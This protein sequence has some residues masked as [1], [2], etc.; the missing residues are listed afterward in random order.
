MIDIA[1][2]I[3]L[4]VPTAEYRGATSDNT[5]ECFDALVWLDERPMPT[6]EQLL[7]QKDAVENY[8]K[9]SSNNK[10]AILERLGLTE[11]ELKVVLS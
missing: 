10:F 9:Q 2:A 3:E 5:K 11:E 4:L 6:W 1:L 7:E 8:K